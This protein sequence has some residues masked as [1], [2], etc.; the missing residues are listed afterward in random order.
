MLGRGSEENARF[1][2]KKTYIYKKSTEKPF[3]ECDHLYQL[4]NV[5][6]VPFIFI[7]L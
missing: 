6:I 5:Q 4:Y 3:S 7:M 1:L 2:K